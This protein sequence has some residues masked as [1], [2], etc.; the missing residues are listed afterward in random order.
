MVMIPKASTIKIYRLSMLIHRTVLILDWIG[1][2]GKRNIHIND[3]S[4]WFVEKWKPLFLQEFQFCLIWWFLQ[5]NT[6]EGNATELILWLDLKNSKLKNTKEQNRITQSKKLFTLNYE[7]RSV[8]I[9]SPFIAITYRSIETYNGG[10]ISRQYA[11]PS[12]IIII[13]INS[14]VENNFITNIRQKCSIKKTH[15]IFGTISTCHKN[16]K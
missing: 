8:N 14:N 13:N 11:V 1:T 16:V 12:T 7:N 6:H 2:C 4:L 9:C 10:H 15:F 3:S 5:I